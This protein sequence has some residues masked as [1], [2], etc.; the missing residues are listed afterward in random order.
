MDA[1]AERLSESSG[2]LLLGLVVRRAVDREPL[3]ALVARDASLE[4]LPAAFGLLGG[5]PF[6]VPLAH[7]ARC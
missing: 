5:W 7:L 2:L 1:A 6:G 4:L 3:L